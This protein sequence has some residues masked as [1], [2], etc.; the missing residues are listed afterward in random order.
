MLWQNVNNDIE[1]EKIISEWVNGLKPSVKDIR[2]IGFLYAI[3]LHTP[4]A[5]SYFLKN[6]ISIIVNGNN[7]IF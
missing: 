3:E 6:K 1:N 5:E 4:P 7:I 2:G